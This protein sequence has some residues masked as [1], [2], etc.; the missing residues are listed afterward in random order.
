MELEFGSG[1]H[2][3]AT[4]IITVVLNIDEFFNTEEQNGIS[5]HKSLTIWFPLET[6]LY[7]IL[8]TCLWNLISHEN[9]TCF[10]G[11]CGLCVLTCSISLHITLKSIHYYVNNLL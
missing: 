7:N 1:D 3:M 5:L 9:A 11:K 10:S 4:A 2:H 8:L 6:Y